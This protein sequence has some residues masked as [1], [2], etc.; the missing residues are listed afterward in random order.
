MKNKA[1][2][3]A[4]AVT[5]LAPAVTTFASTDTTVTG[6]QNQPINSELN[7][8]GQVFND[9]GEAPSGQISMTLPTAV[10]FSV[11]SDGTFIG[12]NGMKVK[13]NS[14]DVNVTV[15]V[16][17]FSDSTPQ[18]LKG[19]TLVD[20]FSSGASTYD[21]S[22]VKLQLTATSGSTVTLK[23]GMDSIKLVDLDA[24][25]I[26]TLALTGEAGQASYNDATTKG[27]TNLE[28]NG[29]SD[30]FVLTFNIAKQ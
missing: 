30:D 20:N 15:S 26:S 25:Q 5:M 8:N 24:G 28:N 18:N 1:L 13:N 11:Y 21:R 14:S 7:I 3:T 19:I 4:M 27:E 9:A 2:L 6:N 12:A 29:I 10:A 16:D 22:H 17:A 23:H